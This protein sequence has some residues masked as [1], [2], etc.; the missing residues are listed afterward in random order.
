MKERIMMH[1]NDFVVSIRP[2]GGGKAF[3]EFKIDG[4]EDDSET[5]IRQINIPFNQE[6]ELVF[7]NM[8]DTRRLVKIS[9]D[10][11]KIGEWV[12]N[13]GN[14]S[15]PYE[16]TLE[17]FMDSDKRFKILHSDD[18]GVGD[19]SDP[20][21]GKVV[22][23]VVDEY[24]PPVFKSRSLRPMNDRRYRGNRHGGSC[25]SGSGFLRGADAPRGSSAG[26]DNIVMA[27][28][29]YASEAVNYSCDSIPISVDLNVD[30][31]D[32][33]SNVATGEG[34]KS[35]QTFTTT[36]WRGNTGTPFIFIFVFNG[37]DRK[38]RD[39]RT[40]F[41]IECGTKLSQDAKFCHKCG[42][43]VAVSAF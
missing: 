17:R 4:E 37:V 13:A 39:E 26:G 25:A 14:K 36:I 8:K 40:G 20:E 21:N 11:D 6:Y 42:T 23:E 19:P 41:C 43:G 10:G 9:I 22:V 1:R 35:G 38:V 32:L 34:S 5:R 16:T 7:K 2:A 27:S 28:A 18:D 31:S 30:T 15:Y 24:K 12:I 3:R 33:E 29:S